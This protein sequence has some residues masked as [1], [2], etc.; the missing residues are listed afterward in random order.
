MTIRRYCRF[1][2]VLVGAIL[3]TLGVIPPVLSD[4]LPEYLQ[5]EWK[6]TSF[7]EVGG[8]VAETP[9]KAAA[10]VGK[11]IRLEPKSFEFQN[12]MLF[13]GSDRCKSPRYHLVRREISEHEIIDKG[14]LMYYGLEGAR[15][16]EIL[17][18]RISCRRADRFVFEVTS[19][20]E[21]AIYYDGNMFFLRKART[22]QK[23]ANLDVSET[24]HGSHFL[25]AT[26]R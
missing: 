2:G 7:Q 4:G 24:T 26:A 20:D 13:F 21:L 23:P 17:E 25:R 1:K 16:N 18:L 11:W 3:A 14:S 22:R 9:E 6:I 12:N 15:D 8:H 19:S 5:S 10:E